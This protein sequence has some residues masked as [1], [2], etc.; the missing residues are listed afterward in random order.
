MKWI[1]RLW[2]C[3]I[4]RNRLDHWSGLVIKSNTID[5]DSFYKGHMTML[6]FCVLRMIAPERQRRKKT[7]RRNSNWSLMRISSSWM[8]MRWVGTQGILGKR[9]PPRQRLGWVKIWKQDF[10]EKWACFSRCVARGHCCN[11]HFKRRGTFWSL[12]HEFSTLVFVFPCDI[13][14]N[15]RAKELTLVSGCT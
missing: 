12:W 10:L 14:E 6:F 7:W 2:T 5:L 8:A 4:V 1:Y 3:C 15:S 13:W 9:A 11:I